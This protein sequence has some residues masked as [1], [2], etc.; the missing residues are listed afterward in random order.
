MKLYQVRTNDHTSDYNSVSE[1]VAAVT[2]AGSGEIAGFNLTPN[3]PPCLPQ[4]VA[5]SY[6]LWTLDCGQWYR[7]D[8]YY[9]NGRD[10]VK[11]TDIT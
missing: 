4:Y 11:A 3:I 6:G 5:R 9:G 7:C 8:L 1:A 2:T 10:P